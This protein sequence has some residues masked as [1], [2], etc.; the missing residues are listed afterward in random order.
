MAAVSQSV[1]D[2]M[3]IVS[4]Q[5]KSLINFFSVFFDA[6]PKFLES[7]LNSILEAT[8]SVE[9][10]YC[11]E[12]VRQAAQDSMSDC[13][14]RSWPGVCGLVIFFGEEFAFQYIA[15]AWKKE[16]TRRLETGQP[17][18]NWTELEFK[19]TIRELNLKPQIALRMDEVGVNSK[20]IMRKQLTIVLSNR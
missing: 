10:F 17:N 2:D 8:G 19:E 14:Q 13:L 1:E 7:L 20:D 3:F 6:T 12:R 5:G 15:S 9:G 4:L 18:L 16:T 11:P